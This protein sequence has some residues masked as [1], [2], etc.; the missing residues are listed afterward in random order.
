[1][2]QLK[3]IVYNYTTENLLINKHFI[4]T[5]RGRNVLLLFSQTS[6]KNQG[7]CSFANEVINP[8][9]NAF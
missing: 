5:I 4:C 2:N 7:F 1:M 9:R 8:V 6:F 3:T